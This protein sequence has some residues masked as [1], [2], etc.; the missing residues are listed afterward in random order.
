MLI[1]S[2]NFIPSILGI[3]LW[4]KQQSIVDAVFSNKRVVVQAGHAVGK[5]YVTSCIILNW[6]YTKPHSKVIVTA[7]TW[8]QVSNV[9]WGTLSKIY[10][11]SI[12]PL[13]GDLT[14]N[15]LVLG[16]DWYAIGMS[17]DKPESFQGIHAHGGVLVV[18]DESI[19]IPKPLWEAADT[20]TA[21]KGCCFLAIANPTTASGPFWEACHNPSWKHIHISCLEHPNVLSGEELIPGSVTKDWVEERKKEYGESS[22]YYQSRVLGLFP[23]ISTSNLI[24][25]QLIETATSSPSTY[26]Y[27]V[28]IDIARYGDDCCVMAIF[29]DWSLIELKKWQHTDLM[30]TCGI[31]IDKIK[32]LNIPPERVNIDVIG[33]GGGV[34]DRLIEQDYNINPINVQS[35]PTYQFKHLT[36]ETLFTNLKSEL[37]WVLRQR[38]T[39]N[40]LFIPPTH[41]EVISDLTCHNYDMDSSG[42]IRIESKKEVK[43]RLSRSPDCGD[44]VVLAMYEHNPP[45]IWAL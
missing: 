12:Y 43:K 30:T 4:S 18:F 14:S 33:V 11:N 32:E 27:S 15:K 22:P 24:S 35:S 23:S 10:Y 3:N 40:L 6:L 31:I 5:S 19:S 38:L 7:N 45:D 8:K 29:K 42:R 26:G 41:Q 44:A 39:K 9:I 13:G 34:V 21:G 17:V 37:W 2:Q 25:R 1:T 36:G 28:G 16:D 20:L